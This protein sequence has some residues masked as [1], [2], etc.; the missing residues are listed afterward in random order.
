M[1]R[2]VALVAALVL[3]GLVAIRVWSGARP[4]DRELLREV[5]SP[6]FVDVPAEAPLGTT[7]AALGGDLA[8]P[9]GEDF[10]NRLLPD[11]AGVLWISCLIVLIVAFDWSR[12]VSWRNFELKIFLI[13]ALVLFDD[14]R[15]F[16]L[17]LTPLSWRLLDSVYEIVFALN[18]VLLLTALWQA[19]VPRTVAEW[20]PNLRGRALAACAVLLLACSVLMALQHD[21]DD[22]GYFTNLGGQRLRE[23]GRLPYGDPLLTGTPGAAYGPLMYV[24]HVPFQFLI[25]PRSPNQT[26]PDL[27]PLGAGATYYLPP[28]L[29]TKLCVI[30]FH[31]AGVLALFVAG[32]RLTWDDDVGWG[33]VALYCG[34]AFVLGIGGVREFIGGITFI[35]HIAPASATLVAFA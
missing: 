17:V 25:D 9:A 21:P 33:L 8:S 16:R 20:R 22:A 12:L 23:R 35:S 34:S 18:A 6:T 28:P 30:A 24:A 4:H 32:R 2:R 3:A 5:Y 7:V 15:F 14:M 19:A 29:A 13:L 1:T 31:L 10:L 11:Q 27:P 26:S